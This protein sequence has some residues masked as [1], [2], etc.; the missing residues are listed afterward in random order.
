MH[1]PWEP[2]NTPEE[3]EARRAAYQRLLAAA[4]RVGMPHQR[5]ASLLSQVAANE[6]QTRRF[7]ADQVY[8]VPDQLLDDLLRVRLSDLAAGKGDE[9]N[10]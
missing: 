2:G 9:Q 4:R 6:E 8:H 5:L 7:L 10:S 3:A 1:H